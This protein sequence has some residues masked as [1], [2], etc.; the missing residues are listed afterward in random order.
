MCIRAC[1]RVW[2]CMCVCVQLQV[3]VCV[4]DCMWVCMWR[5]Y[6]LDIYKMNAK[7]T[8]MLFLIFT[9]DIVVIHLFIFT[10][11]GKC[12]ICLSNIGYDCHRT[13]K[14]LCL[15]R[16]MWQS[17][18]TMFNNHLQS[19]LPDCKRLDFYIYVWMIPLMYKTTDGN[20]CRSLK[21]STTCRKLF[22]SIAGDI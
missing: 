14:P 15:V 2:I 1:V 17:I 10:I 8:F 5:L 7:S 9:N 19:Y 13:F 16:H 22:S 3:C 18:R 6:E 21:V 4:C 12:F 20:R 11:L